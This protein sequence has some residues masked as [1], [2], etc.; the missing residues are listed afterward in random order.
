MKKLFSILFFIH[1]VSLSVFAQ[2]QEGKASFY[3]DKFEGRPTASGD[4]YR[5]NKLTAAHKS[6][7]FGTIVRVT[8]LANGNSVE[9]EINDR[10]PYVDGRIIDVSRSA[11]EKLGFIN[12]GIADVKMEIV[13]AGDGKG[14][15][16]VQPIANVAVDEA[17]FYE[18]EV[19]RI[20]A[21]GYGVQIG[22]YQE[23]ANLVRFCENLK[24]SYRKKVTV[25]VKVING[26]KVY[27]VIV[28]QFTAREKAEEFKSEVMP[29]FPDAFIV[30]FTK[31][32]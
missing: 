1:F 2:V 24:S 17:E 26:V 29:R 25:Q 5:H 22:S 11:A 12:Q 18:F 30:D 16:V 15:T 6:L 28:G 14:G 20:Y 32:K 8:N 27:T 3:A 21:L 10:G 4:K 9:L 31:L 7:P 19:S 23:L 13:D